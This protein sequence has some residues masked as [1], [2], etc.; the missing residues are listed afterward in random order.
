VPIYGQ[1]VSVRARIHT[2]SGLS[3]HADVEETLEWLGGFERPPGTTYLVHGEPGASAA[4]AQTL[5]QRLHWHAEV[6]QYLQEV[7][8]IRG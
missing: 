2:L 7:E 6:A 1:D 3:A 4:L 5:R 8:L